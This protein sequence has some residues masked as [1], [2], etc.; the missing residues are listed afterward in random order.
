MIEYLVLI[1]CLG[2]LA[3]LIPGRHRKYAAIIG[4]VFIVAFLF[5]DLPEYFSE[6][7]FLYPVMA[8]LSVP[9]LLITI[10]YLLEENT[11][12]LHL[13]RAAA[14]AFLIYAPFT[15]IPEAGNWLISAVV[16]E[17]VWLLQ[18][19]NYPVNLDAWNII[20]RNSFRVEIILACTGI[21]SIAIMLG[22][23][24]AVPT[25]LRQKILAFLLVGPTIYIL[26]LFRNVFVIMAY[27]GQWFPYWSDIAGNGEYGYESFFWA[28]NV[29]AE[30]LALVALILIAYGLFVLIPQLGNFAD[31]L[32]QLYYGEI[33]HDLERI[34]GKGPQKPA[35][36]PAPEPV[37]VAESSGDTEPPQT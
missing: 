4:W 17:V 22:V 27:T 14:V 8:I 21:Q 28:H 19:F 9:F 7:N 29:I 1:S 2:F 26:N 35:A 5:A 30:M 36:S 6:N 34:R 11:A 31:E 16:G 15:Y 37:P 23:A 18:V 33:V 25:T 10:R 12:V 24:A 32:Y 13:S 3:S 20:A